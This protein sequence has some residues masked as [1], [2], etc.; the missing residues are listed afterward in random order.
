MSSE[1]PWIV[2]REASESDVTAIRDIFKDVYHED[3]PY[4]WFFD[5]T[6]LK[7]SVFND[8]IMMLVAENED[9]QEILGTASVMF[10]T[11][12]HSDLVGE[13]GRLVVKPSAR[14]YGIGNLLMKKRLELVKTRLHLGLV[15]NRTTHPFSQRIST[16]H[17]FA[18]V[19]FLP[20]KHK[21][22]KRESVAVFIKHF[23]PALCLRRNHPHII[24]EAHNLAHFALENCGLPYDAIIDE[25]SSAYPPCNEFELEK[26]TNVGLPALIRIERGRLHNREV[27]GPMGLQYGFFRLRARHATYLVAREPGASVQS[28]PIAGAIGYIIDEEEKALR[29]FELVSRTDQVVRYLF[30]NL[31]ELCRTKWKVEYVEVDVSAHAPRMQ[32]TLLEL[33]FLPSAYIP[34]MVFHNVERLDVLKMVHLQ[35]PFD[36]KTIALI[37]EVQTIADQVIRSFSNQEI[38][39]IISRTVNRMHLFGGLDEEQ[40]A[41]LAGMCGISRFHKGETLIHQNE[42][43]EKMFIVIEGKLRVMMEDSASPVGEVVSGEPVGELSFLTGEKH[44]ASVIA[45]TPCLAVSL[46]SPDLLKLVRQRPDI[47]LIVYRN[48][49]ISVG[50]KL[51]RSDNVVSR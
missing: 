36:V 16:A 25:D 33:G 20:M 46:A 13:F 37:P 17:G 44:S 30:H 24:P 23:G 48:L 3:Y 10:D 28:G 22:Q 41:R 32:R 47:G 12:A 2:V 40:T 43:A 6:W 49:A 15:E 50:K 38:L 35:V 39:P 26:L 34:A 5:E 8:D 51:Q 1:N 9:T 29:V 31:L 42:T 19:G 18:P 27:F 21:L 4:H 14:K 45:E 7:R 11:G